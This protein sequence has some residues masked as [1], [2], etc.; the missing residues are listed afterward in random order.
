MVPLEGKGRVNDLSQGIFAPQNSETFTGSFYVN[1]VIS[2]QTKTTL[3]LIT[4]CNFSF[5]FE[6]S[7]VKKHLR[8]LMMFSK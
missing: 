3:D 1:S 6:F 8:K 7:V 2:F 5:R 4:C